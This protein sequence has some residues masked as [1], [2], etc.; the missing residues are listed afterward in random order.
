MI[1]ASVRKGLNPALPVI[2]FPFDFQANANDL[3]DFF[4]TFG[5]VL[6]GKVVLDS[7]G[8]SRR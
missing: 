7:Y 3:A 4:G 8:R 2:Y 5:T 6:E 1:S